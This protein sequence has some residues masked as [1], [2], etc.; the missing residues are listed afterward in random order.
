MNKSMKSQ[1]ENHPKPGK[2]LFACWAA[3]IGLFILSAVVGLFIFGFEATDRFLF[4]NTVII[5]FA[6]MA[7]SYPIIKNKLK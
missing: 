6:F 4:E 2:I 5:L 1:S 7:I 3:A